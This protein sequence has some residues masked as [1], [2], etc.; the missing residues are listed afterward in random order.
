MALVAFGVDLDK[1]QKAHAALIWT[2]HVECHARILPSA[3][4]VDS[5]P[6][7][8]IHVYM[9]TRIIVYMYNCIHA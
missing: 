7:K 4:G 2:N 5:L 9:Y 3:F 6:Q 1:C 8:R